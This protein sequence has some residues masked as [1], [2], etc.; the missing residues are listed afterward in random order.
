MKL[1]HLA[2]L[3]LDSP[4]QGIRQSNSL[5]REKLLAAPYEAFRQAIGVAINRQ[6]DVVIIAGDIYDSDRQTI[7]AQHQFIQELE[8]LEQADI[9]VVMIHGNHDY[10]NSHS[11]KMTYPTNV[12]LLD[13]Q[14][15]DSVELRLSNGHSARFYGFSYNQRWIESNK[16]V[17]Y[18]RAKGETDYTIGILHGSQ[19][20]GNPSSDRYAPFRVKDLL[21]CQYDYWALGHI[22][23]HQ[24]LNQEPLIQYSG[25]SQGRNRLET[26]DKGGYLV[27]LEKNQPTKSEFISLSSIE[28][29]VGRLDCQE[30][31]QIPDLLAACK[32]WLSTY[33]EVASSTKKLYLLS[34]YLDNAQRLDPQIQ[35]QIISEDLIPLLN[36]SDLEA[37]SYWLVKLELSY[38]QLGDSFDYDPQLKKSFEASLASLEEGSSYQDMLADLFGH[39]ILMSRLSD[40]KSDPLIKEEVSNQAQARIT[41]V[42][43]MNQEGFEDAD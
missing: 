32:K 7:Y 43:G 30:D 35:E 36:P 10:L 27:T 39:P 5:L 25:T 24:V 41:Q 4:F 21:A 37:N 14:A 9:P 31:W 33:R 20:S 16:A 28:W 19:A 29:Q 15:I 34:L 12:Y 11:P 2:D 38:D 13:S 6:V 26:G 8:R 23:Q 17:E 3:H 22:H 42:L 40:I 18:P 1:L